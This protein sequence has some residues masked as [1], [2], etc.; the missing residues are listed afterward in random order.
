MPDQQKN[1][2]K[3]YQ[4]Y[5]TQSTEHNCVTSLQCFHPM[6]IKFPVPT[7][8]RL[9][10]FQYPCLL[11]IQNILI[12]LTSLVWSPEFQ[13]FLHNYAMSEGQQFGEI[14]ISMFG[15]FL[16]YLSCKLHFEDCI[17]SFFLQ[18]PQSTGGVPIY[19]YEYEMHIKYTQL[20][21]TQTLGACMSK[22]VRKKSLQYHLW[23]GVCCES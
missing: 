15:I 14:S 3:P 23:F 8:G 13:S 12:A 17:L 19:V 20:S 18:V 4:F 10:H 5:N 21:H 1:P 11:Q 6:R 16:L 2:T 22:D 7:C 9:S